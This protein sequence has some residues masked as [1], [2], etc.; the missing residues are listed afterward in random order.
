MLIFFLPQ[1]KLSHDE[2]LNY[3]ES[4]RLFCVLAI[5]T[6]VGATI[7]F[8]LILLGYTKLWVVVPTGIGGLVSYILLGIQVWR[9]SKRSKR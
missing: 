3:A 7:S 9:D 4:L 5:P 2:F 6:I 1:R 8:V